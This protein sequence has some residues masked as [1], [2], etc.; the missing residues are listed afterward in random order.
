MPQQTIGGT[1]KTCLSNELHAVDNSIRLEVCAPD[2]CTSSSADP[3]ARY[4]CILAG[5]VLPL[6]LPS[7]V[8]D[9][10]HPF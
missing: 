2:R 4:V 10:E 7:A 6:S 8:T 5:L 1:S 3:T 9:H